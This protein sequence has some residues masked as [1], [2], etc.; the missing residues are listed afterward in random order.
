MNPDSK[1]VAI[2]RG[3]I[4]DIIFGTVFLFFGMIACAIAAIRRRSGVRLILWLESGAECGAC[5]SWR[6]NRP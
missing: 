5:G 1:V 6:N 3:Q 2:L 4:A